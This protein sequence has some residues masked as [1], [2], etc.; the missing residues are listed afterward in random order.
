MRRVFT[1]SATFVAGM[2]LAGT[3]V[4]ERPPII[5]NRQPPSAIARPQ[6]TKPDRISTDRREDSPFDPSQTVSICGARTKKGKPC[7]RRVIGTG[8]CFQHRGKSAMLPAE[9]LIVQN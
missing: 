5:I 6:F 7:S 3:L 8:R 4:K 1:L 9:K 2:V